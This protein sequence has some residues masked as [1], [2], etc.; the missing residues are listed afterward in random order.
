MEPDQALKDHLGDAIDQ[1]VFEHG[2]VTDFEAL[3]DVVVQY[4]VDKIIHAAAITPRLDREMAEPARIIDVNFGSTVH[5]LELIRTIP[6]IERMVYIS[7]GAAWG[8]GHDGDVIDETAPSLADGLYGVLKHTAERVVRRY[9]ELF[10]IDVVA[11][12]PAS[13]YGPM[14]RVTPGY[15]GATELREMLRIATAGEPILVSSLEGPYHDWTYV[16]D[17]AEGIERAWAT[18]DLP[19]DVYSI[20]CGRLYSIGDMLAAFARHWPGLEYR[21][22]SESE[23]N[24]IVSG[25]PPGPTPSN[26]RMKADFGWEP[27]TSLDAGVADYIA[28]VREYGPQ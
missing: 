6:R 23:A 2:D 21:E 27:S 12:R 9:H 4:D 18:S 24:Y 13:V 28:W 3:H 17:I 7:S 1:V 14:E 25:S 10:D 5:C 11:M 16:E 8:S 20:T 22:V 26:A 15:S 19:N